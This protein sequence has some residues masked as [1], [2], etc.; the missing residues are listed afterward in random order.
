MAAKGS[1]AQRMAS[2]ASTVENWDDDGDFDGSVDMFTH[3]MSTFQ[4]TSSR[5]SVRSESNTGDDDWQVL[6]APN[7][8]ASTMNAISS[9]KQ[10]GIP[11]PTS[12]P[13]S[14]L[15]GGAIK[16]LGKK[17]SSRKIAVDE[18]WGND[19]ELPNNPGEGLKLK[20]PMPR[21][22][23]DDNDGFDDDWGEG[24]L[25]I[26]F[27]GTSRGGR[28]ARSSS[29]S[30]MSPSMGSIVT[31]ESEDDELNG[32]VLPTEPLDFASRLEK[33]KK[34]DLPTPDTS[35]SGFTL[36]KRAPPPTSAPVL[37]PP[38]EFAPS[39]APSWPSPSQFEKE[40]ATPAQ[41]EPAP[42]SRLIGVEEE[43]DFMDGLDIGG[44]EVLDTNKLT[45]N[46]NVK[47]KKAPAKVTPP[48]AA[49]PATTLTFTDKDKPS[50]SKIPRPLSTSSRSRL[51]P[52][53]ESGASQS[54]NSRQ[55]PTTTSAQLLRAKRSAPLLRN[56]NPALSAR[57]SV[58][59]LPAGNSTSQSHHVMAKST[60]RGHL[61]RDSDPRRPPSPSMRPYSR[62]PFD[63][64]SR[65]GMR[66][67]LAP[68][69]LARH[70]QKLTFPKGR[71][72]NF[73]DGTELEVF[74]DLPTSAHKEKQFEKAPRNVAS[75]K[76]LRSQTSISK[77]P[78][79]DRMATPMPQT[80]RS[81]PKVDH[82]PR[83]ARDTAASRNARE[84]RLASIRT[85]GDGPVPPSPGINWKVHVAAKSPHTSPIAHRKKGSGAKPQLIRGL[86]EPGSRTE[87]GMIYNP[88][89]QRWEGNE[90]ALAP[91]TH[92]NT[93]TAT[94]DL[95]TVS[96][97][98][99]SPVHNPFGHPHERSH[100][101]SHTALSQIQLKNV[102]SRAVK[103]VARPIPSPPRPALISQKT[104]PRGVQYEG[105][106]VFDPVKMTW[107]K[108][109][110]ES[111]DPRSPSVADDDEE[112]PFAG[113][114]DLKDNVSV[115]GP[116]DS[117]S[118][119]PSAEDISFVGE[120]FDLGP[121]F[122]RRQREEE[123][124]WRRKTESWVGTM[125]DSGEHKH[126][127][128]WELRRIAMRASEER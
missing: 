110:R 77:L 1:F 92:P 98:T 15:L 61:R 17:K 54:G 76:T 18:D 44:G 71:K 106:M 4:S 5:V 112:D 63:T 117:V 124:I 58:P 125:R 123:A 95:T 78:M 28:G 128:R 31:L 103:V 96:T 127:W 70:P 99:F 84:Q 33:L 69:A 29:V 74:D 104:M 56:N 13:S 47:V 86:F 48:P 45:L 87:K 3:S 39:P 26:R 24:S 72:Q 42:A 19:L 97:P 62:G 111:N 126:G 122:I 2:M 113:L 81:P 90:E 32:L 14:A 11:I 20:A 120:E 109:P 108:A 115:A 30:A 9:A 27:A 25:G 22:P 16:R 65:N 6:L 85:R 53:Y 35:P 89:M 94:L 107:L 57:S 36:P 7:D 80:P 55:P 21:T 46:R 88:T 12:V 59:F 100:S 79:P 121:S 37:G 41:P 73:G 83:F 64:P 75:N 93:S 105:R 43:D 82:T 49:R 67:E 8:E 119:G 68:S 101:I 91:F 116:G 10:A 34:H 23:A 102:S 52:V 60:S 40:A 38:L 50:M 118:G 66:R 51:T 114:E